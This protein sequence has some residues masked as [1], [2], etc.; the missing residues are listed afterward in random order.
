[1]IRRGTN[2]GVSTKFYRHFATQVKVKRGPEKANLNLIKAAQN[3]GEPPER[4]IAGWRTTQASKEF[5]ETALRAILQE[6]EI[7]LRDN[8]FKFQKEKYK[9][10]TVND[11]LKTHYGFSVK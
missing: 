9:D 6:Y 5:P 7:R 8:L 1:M 4:D 11:F 2:L 10:M 3:I